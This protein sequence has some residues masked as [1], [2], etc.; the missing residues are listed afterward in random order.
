VLLAALSLWSCAG[1]ERSITPVDDAYVLIDA[2]AVTS[3]V[4]LA[5][6]LR[7]LGALEVA[8][9]GRVVSCFFP[10][11]EFEQLESLA[12]LHSFRVATATTCVD[13]QCQDDVTE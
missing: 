5:S 2:T 11:L 6:D 10:M 1:N 13:P 9:A 4:Q 3:G 12:S 8:V 7:K